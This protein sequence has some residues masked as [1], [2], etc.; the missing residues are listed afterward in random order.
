[1]SQAA[2]IQHRQTDRLAGSD[3]V[4]SIR[5]GH[6]FNDKTPLKTRRQTEDQGQTAK[7][8]GKQERQ[9]DGRQRPKIRSAIRRQRKDRKKRTKIKCRQLTK[10]GKSKADTKIDRP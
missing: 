7:A 4:F 5:V 6:S 1:M 8:E 2:T 10:R 9:K 3:R